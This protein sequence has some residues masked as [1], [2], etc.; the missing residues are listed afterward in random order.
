MDSAPSL[1]SKTK[2]LP[3]RASTHL[4]AK[5]RCAVAAL[6]RL[7]VRCGVMAAQLADLLVRGSTLPA[8]EGT[9]VVVYEGY[10]TNKT[11]LEGEAS[12][13]KMTLKRTNIFVN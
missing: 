11:V 13:A 2:E 5:S 6:A 7:R 10:V 9:C 4:Q 3:S 12:T 8:A 1:C